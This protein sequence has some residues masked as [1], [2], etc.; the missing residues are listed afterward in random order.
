MFYLYLLVIPTSEAFV[1]QRPP[2]QAVGDAGKSVPER[3]ERM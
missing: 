1:L 2:V 3:L